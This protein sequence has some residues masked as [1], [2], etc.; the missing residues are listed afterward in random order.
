[1]TP[2]GME[3]SHSCGNT[4]T[5]RYLGEPGKLAAPHKRRLIIHH[6]KVTQSKI[7]PKAFPKLS[8]VSPPQEQSK[9]KSNGIK[10]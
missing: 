1:M 6:D 8:N 10:Q 7:A 9:I 5:L 4:A 3:L 2:L